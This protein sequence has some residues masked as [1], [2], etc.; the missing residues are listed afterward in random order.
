MLPIWSTLPPLFFV[1]RLRLCGILQVL[2]GSEM[3]VGYEHL[4]CE[5]EQVGMVRGDSLW[6]DYILGAY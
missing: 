4:V 6:L 5:Q 3:G 2:Q 1:L